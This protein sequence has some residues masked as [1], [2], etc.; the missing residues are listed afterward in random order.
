MGVS[1]SVAGRAPSRGVDLQ[2]PGI[3]R[4][5]LPLA[6]IVALGLALRLFRLDAASFWLDEMFS[7]WWV[8][9]EFGFLWSEGMRL[10]PNPPLYYT[11]L[12]GWTALLGARDE[13]AVRSLSVLLSVAT[14][15]LVALIGREVA[16]RRAGLLAAAL[17]A[18]APVQVHYAQEGRTYALLTLVTAAALLGTLRFLR[19]AAHGGSGRRWLALYAA[20]AVGM[21]Y[22]H[23]TAAIT[24][25]AL[26]LCALGWLLAAPARRRAVVPLVA[27]NIGV[28][29]LAVP[30]ILTM[31]G[32]MGRAHELAFIAGPGLV[33]FL[34][35]AN[36]LL[37]DP[38]TPWVEFRL[39]SLTAG[40]VAGLLLLLLA[41]ARPPA[42]ILLFLGAVPAL[43][44]V[45]ALLAGF[46]APVL[47]PRVVTW[48]SVPFCILAAIALLSPRP[49]VALRAGF[50][51]ALCVATLLG[52]HGV[53]MRTA[54]VKEDWR[55]LAATLGR[56]AAPEDL[57]AFGSGGAVV[58]LR[59][60]GP[61]GLSPHVWVPEGAT[62]TP[63]LQLGVPLPPPVTGAEIARAIAAGRR[64]HLVLWAPDWARH[65]AEAL[66]IVPGR[67]PRVDR[68]HARLVML[69]W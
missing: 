27:A 69:S 63:F 28:V 39:A 49:P 6:A 43:F 37:V 57:L 47:M 9:H 11:L 32:Y 41:I 18:V 16:G 1:G 66:A 65:G 55:G 33:E 45:L 5:V 7:A 26:N 25:A 29:L 20:A 68:R 23:A 24:L 53:H 14:I 64:A 54:A 40:T 21:I 12:K 8:G 58:M 48:M 46:A 44:I 61:A 62:Y 19:A 30:Q 56:Q 17:F 52:Q 31:L 60:Y 50:A 67:P 4:R 3:L 15:P 22:S 59:V 10:E 42:E 38:N 35:L 51:L 36:V 2:P 34:N 13:A